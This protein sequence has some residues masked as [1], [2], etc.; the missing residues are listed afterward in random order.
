[1][2]I[3]PLHVHPAA[4][5]EAGPLESLATN[6]SLTEKEKLKEASRQFEAL[7]LRQILAQGRKPLF[8]SKLT[9]ESTGSS[10]YQDMVNQQL[11]DAISQSGGFGLARSLELQLTPPQQKPM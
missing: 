5:P 6:K 9:E 10:I 7:I 1:V 2:N 8:H 3:S 11:A 4:R